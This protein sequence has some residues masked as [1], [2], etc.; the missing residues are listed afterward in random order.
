[1]LLNP[2]AFTSSNVD[3]T[4]GAL[5]Q[6]PSFGTASRVFPKFH[7]GLIAATYVLAETGLKVAVHDPV[8]EAVVEEEL[9]ESVTELELETLAEVDVVKAEVDFVEDEKLEPGSSRHW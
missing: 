8:G 5:F 4:T 3:A 1:M 9:E 2:A 7:P 6:E